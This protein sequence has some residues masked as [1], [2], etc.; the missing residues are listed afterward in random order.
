MSV[1]ADDLE[2]VVYEDRQ[3]LSRAMF[4]LACQQW[5]RPPDSSYVTVDQIRV[6]L[7]EIFILELAE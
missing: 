3:S 4:M 2:V 5:N 1:E 6:V 7:G